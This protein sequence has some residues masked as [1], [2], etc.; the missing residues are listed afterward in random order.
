MSNLKEER[1]GKTTIGIF[2]HFGKNEGEIEE[3]LQI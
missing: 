1:K 2:K 3:D